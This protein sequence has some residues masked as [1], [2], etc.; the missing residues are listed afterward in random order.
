MT[1]FP[2]PFTAFSRTKK[3][4]GE[5]EEVIAENI[6]NAAAQDAE[7]GKA[8]AFVIAQEGR[9]HLIKKIQGEHIFNGAH[10]RLR[11]HQQGA[12]DGKGQGVFSTF[13]CRK[14]RQEARKI[15]DLTGLLT[16]GK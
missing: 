2:T 15:Y 14:K 1:A 13:F 5:N 3:K 16:K 12:V 6:E 4:A 10:I 8:R 11:Q 7:G 9:H